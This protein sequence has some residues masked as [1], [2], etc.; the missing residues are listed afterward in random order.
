MRSVDV[1]GRRLPVAKRPGRGRPA[2]RVL[3]SGRDEHRGCTRFV[4]VVLKLQTHLPLVVSAERTVIG[5]GLGTFDWSTLR[6]ITQR[7]MIIA[8]A[9]ASDAHHKA[10]YQGPHTRPLVVRRTTARLPTGFTRPGCAVSD[11]LPTP[12]SI[13]PTG[14]PGTRLVQVVS[15]R[16]G[17]DAD[18]AAL[19]RRRPRR[20]AADPPA[21]PALELRQSAY[22]FPG[23]SQA[24]HS[25]REQ[26]GAVRFAPIGGNSGAN[27]APSSGYA[28][29]HG[30]PGRHFKPRACRYRPSIRAR[31]C[32]VYR[33]CPS[34]CLPRS[35]R[36]GLG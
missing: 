29:Q 8:A 2:R 13:S 36:A 6:R 28:E 32:A 18:L 7:P 25:C 9:T 20:R 30:T 33:H 10:S 26:T 19:D 15:A 34:L 16:R 22:R 31:A 5:S 12:R 23:H 24:V 1:R 35:R 4:L 14:E 17:R 3:L 21:I 27:R 11:G